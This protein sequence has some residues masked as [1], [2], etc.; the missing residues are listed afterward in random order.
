MTFVSEKA[1][2]LPGIVKNSDDAPKVNFFP[3]FNN[4]K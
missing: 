2:P 3:V 4:G 1:A